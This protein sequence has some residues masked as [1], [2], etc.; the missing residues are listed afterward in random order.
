MTD[1]PS[2]ARQQTKPPDVPAP[3]LPYQP[4]DP[5]SYRPG[6]GLIGCGAITVEHLAAYRT[7]GYRVL[8]L[9]DLDRGAAEKRR[10]EFF[11]NAKVYTDHRDLLANDDIEVVD[12]TPHPHQRPPLVEDAIRAR[13]HVLSQKPFVT[14]LDV[15]ER[16]VEL[17]EEHEV[18]LAVNQ[19]GRWAPHFCYLRLAV[20]EGLIGDV[21]GVH[22][23]V[24]WD[25]TWVKGT[26]FENVRHLILFDFAIHWFDMLGCLM[27]GPGQGT[28]GETVARPQSVF[29]SIARTP[30][31]PVRPALLGQAMV[32]YE[33]AQAS[34]VFGGHTPQGEIDS[35]FVTGTTGT[36]MSTG[37][38]LN[39]QCVTLHTAAGVASPR[40]EGRWFPDGFHGTMGELLCAIEEDREP[41]HSARNNL[42]TVSLCLAAMASADQGRPVVP[43]TVRQ[44]PE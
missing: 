2:A 32:Q 6:I 33:H 9:C 42:Q 8:G 26:E 37:T 30:N 34:L 22:F 10:G 16:L 41:S 20:A 27:A 17:A 11:P 5:R 24:H 29:A 1:H 7:A 40:L 4:R 19:N 44:M 18:R 15:G 14:D 21:T 28:D 38:E 36:L 3:H 23:Q 35:T 12:I 25:H 31:Q 13:R 43:G 39:T